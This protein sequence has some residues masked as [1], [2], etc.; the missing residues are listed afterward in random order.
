MLSLLIA[1]LAACGSG[2]LAANW[3]H[4]K[5]W[6][7]FIAFLV[8]FG[9]TLLLNRLI[10]KRL[11]SLIE[12][13]QNLMQQAQLEA[14]R[15]AQ[16]FM[17]KPM[18]SQKV[19]QKQLEKIVEKSVLQ[20]LDLLDQAKPLYKWNLLAERQINTVKFQ[21]NF[22][23]KRFEVCDKLM[24]KLFIADPLTMAMKITRLYKKDSDELEKYFRKGIRKFRN[25]KGVL[26]YALY[27]WILVKQKNYDKALEVLAEAKEKTENETILHNW[28]MLVND[29][30]KQ[31]SNAGLGEQWYAL[32]LE[33]P[34]A[35]RAGKGQMKSNPMMP[36]NRRRYF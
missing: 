32:H 9:V 2:A 13:V 15:M 33:M 21:L 5:G 26:I 3:I 19:M 36:K 29:R 17:N 31:F 30:V 16:R 28:E 8:F 18:S 25:D 1:I 4:S 20:A 24:D 10:T 7:G 6:I 23:I 12:E 34:K 22:Q 35:A 11:S 14:N 27:S